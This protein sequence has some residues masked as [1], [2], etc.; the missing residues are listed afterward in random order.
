MKKLS[1]EQMEITKGGKFIGTTTKCSDCI[2]GHRF[3]LD[4][5]YFFWIRIGAPR[6]YEEA[7]TVY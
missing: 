5:D 6:P 1:I 2:S 3:C 4:Q 7:C